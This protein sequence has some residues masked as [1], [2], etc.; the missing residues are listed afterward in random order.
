MKKNMKKVL[1]LALVV[2]LVFLSGCGDKT[3]NEKTGDAKEKAKVEKSDDKD[4]KDDSKKEKAGDKSGSKSKKEK[5]GE[6]NKQSSK[7]SNVKSSG[8]ASGNKAPKSGNVSNGGNKITKRVVKTPAPKKRYTVV[9]DKTTWKKK[10]GKGR[11]AEGGGTHK[12]PK[13]W[14]DDLF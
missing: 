3:D 8:N 4:K 2:G 11:Y 14:N 13:D 6:S 9:K 1:S 7:P 5:A 10:I 12:L